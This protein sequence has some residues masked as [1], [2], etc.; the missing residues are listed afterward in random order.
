MAK[1][2][3]SKLLQADNPI[4]VAAGGLGFTSKESTEWS[5]AATAAPE[6]AVFDL[7]VEDFTV[8]CARSPSLF[9]RE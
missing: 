7:N 5:A 1:F 2:P 4:R 6:E 9:P 3:W 8:A